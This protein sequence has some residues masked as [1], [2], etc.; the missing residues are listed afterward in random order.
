MAIK[1]LNEKINM[2]LDNMSD[3][4]LENVLNILN[5]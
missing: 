4:I 1:E 5:H 3:D 2:V